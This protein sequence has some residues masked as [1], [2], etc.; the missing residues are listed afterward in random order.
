M[1]SAAVDAVYGEPA[2]FIYRPHAH[3]SDVNAPFAPD[4]DRPVMTITA[5]FID[6][7]AR[8]HSGPARVQGVKPDARPGHASTRPMI[9]IDKAQLP[10][11]VRQG[12]RIER[13]KTGQLYHLA[14]PRRDDMQRIE[15]D[16]NLL[17][18]GQ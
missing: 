1:A 11:E 12:D 17:R 18:P 2:G 7:F 4:P 16:L 9:S 13:I 6:S 8:A 14:E 15:V 5:A 10:Y 3:V